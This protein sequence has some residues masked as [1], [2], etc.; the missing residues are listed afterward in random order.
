MRVTLHVQNL[1]IAG[2]PS[3]TPP[4]NE[5]TNKTQPELQYFKKQQPNY[6]VIH[7]VAVS[8]LLETLLVG[9][10]VFQRLDISAWKESAVQ[11]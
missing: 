6:L 1:K 2:V 3:G 7:H 4:Q 11:L 9:I 10:C 5:R 8:G